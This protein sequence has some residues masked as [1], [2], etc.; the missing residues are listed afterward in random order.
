MTDPMT[1]ERFEQLADAY[2]GAVA[3]WPRSVR[4]AATRMAVEPAASAI[5]ARA[6]TLDESLDGWAVPATSSTLRKRILTDMPAPSHRVV[7]RAKLWWS[8]IGIAATLAGAAAGT[9]AVAMAPSV[10]AGS[11]IAT[12]FG[13]IGAR[14]S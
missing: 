2:G 11:G 12:S 4:D 13:D 7:K 9:A 3:R 1:L 5:L 8:G 6:A 14:D 10:D